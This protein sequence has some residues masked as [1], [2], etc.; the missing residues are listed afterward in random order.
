LA[1][2]AALVWAPAALAAPPP[3]DDAAS[4]VP[5]AALPYSVV[6]DNTEATYTFVDDRSSCG[7]SHSVWYSFTPPN[8]M[9]LTPTVSGIGGYLPGLAAFTGVA[10][11]LSAVPLASP[12]CPY[13]SFEAKAGTT[14]RFLVGGNTTEGGQ[15][16]FSLSGTSRAHISL[17]AS[18]TNVRYGD[19]MTVRVHLS[20]MA[21]TTNHV[22]SIYKLSPKTLIRRGAVD[23]NG[24]LSLK[25]KPLKKTRLVAE[26][27][28]EAGWFPATSAIVTVN[29]RV[30][31]RIKLLGYYGQ[32]GGYKLYQAGHNPV[33][34]GTVVPNHRGR[35]LEFI[36]DKLVNGR[37]QHV[38]R[39]SFRIGNNGS[40][41]VIFANPR[42][43]L[44]YRVRA[45]FNGDLDHV[46]GVAPWQFLRVT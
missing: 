41:V 34:V 45:V 5:I 42:R 44:S 31:V 15:F 36:A 26:W 33:L 14:Y 2:V 3:N 21:A 32:A 29:V 37:W 23:A 6:G 25:L 1:I 20:D 19:R 4:P 38:D 13:P 12:G 39:V 27:A 18:Q 35:P 43:G 10:G 22:V 7:E 40:A 16:T 24:N 8:D 17:T 28:G 9:R 46:K 11:A 30:I